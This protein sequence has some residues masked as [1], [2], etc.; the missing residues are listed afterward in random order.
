MV[1]KKFYFLAK[2]LKTCQTPKHFG[3]ELSGKTPQ[4]L[5]IS[6]KKTTFVA[7]TDR[8]FGDFWQGRTDTHNQ[9]NRRTQLLF[10]QRNSTLFP[11]NGK[12]KRKPS[13]S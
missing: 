10:S 1:L 9:S 4:K 8:L 2:L 11:S 7:T 6:P 13:N 3:R 12:H 5:A